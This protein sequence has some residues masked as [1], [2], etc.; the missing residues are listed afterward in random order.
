MKYCQNCQG[1]RE[2]LTN[3]KTCLECS[4]S[5][6]VS[7]SSQ[8]NK[9]EKSIA[10]LIEKVKKEK[11]EEQFIQELQG[12]H[13]VCQEFQAIQKTEEENNLAVQKFGQELIDKLL[14]ELNSR[15]IRI[16]NW[17]T[18]QAVVSS[19]RDNGELSRLIANE[20]E[21]KLQNLRGELGAKLENLP[22]ELRAKLNLEVEQMFSQEIQSLMG[23]LTGKLDLANLAS[24]SNSEVAAMYRQLIEDLK[25]GHEDYKTLKENLIEEIRT[26]K[27]QAQQA[28]VSEQ[29]EHVK[30]KQNKEDLIQQIKQVLGLDKKDELAENWITQIVKQEELVQE[31][32][33]HNLTKEKYQNLQTSYSSL[34]KELQT[35]KDNHAKTNSAL[36]TEQTEHKKTKE[37]L[38]A[39]KEV[40]QKL[41]TEFEKEKLAAEETIRLANEAKEAAI[42]EKNE[43]EV[44]REASQKSV[45]ELEKQLTEKENKNNELTTQ[46]AEKD[47]QIKELQNNNNSLTENVKELKECLENYQKYLHS[48][49]Q[50]AEEALTAPFFTEVQQQEIGQEKQE[51][52]AKILQIEQFIRKVKLAVEVNE[53]VK[54]YEEDLK[55]SHEAIRLAEETKTEIESKYVQERLIKE[56]ILQEKEELETK[57]KLV[58]KTGKKAETT[59]DIAEELSESV[60]SEKEE[61]QPT[62]P[63]ITVDDYESEKE[64]SENLLGKQKKLTELEGEKKQLEQAVKDLQKKGVDENELATSQANLQAKKKELEELRNQ[65]EQ[66][67]TAWEKLMLKKEV[68][69]QQQIQQLQDERNRLAGEKRILEELLAERKAECQEISNQLTEKEKEL[70]KT[71]LGQ[72]ELET[73]RA[74]KARLEGELRGA[75]KDQTRLENKLGETEQ[76]L[77]TNQKA[78]DLLLQEQ[79]QESDL[80][81]TVSSTEV[82]EKTLKEKYPAQE[83]LIGLENRVN[84]RPKTKEISEAKELIEKQVKS[85]PTSSSMK[86]SG[87]ASPMRRQLS[88]PQQARIQQSELPPFFKKD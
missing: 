60:G 29:I 51:Y 68:E 66:E 72:E 25:A 34:T 70:L 80:L 65:F 44:A 74:E 32:A 6:L 37:Q 23:S 55:A 13:Q 14:Q 82:K 45:T 46:F 20:L 7:L 88:N 49:I 18:R 28:L 1:F 8:I 27:N 10:Q 4:Q 31:Q 85:Q 63:E 69:A 53:L 38:A 62:L 35:E 19:F 48:Q 9:L 21:A 67:K 26:A 40:L 42:Q 11:I 5:S 73:L 81:L 56:Q 36:I 16:V 58:N 87:S 86:R 61:V 41:Q 59:L 77:Q 71:K 15:Q 3:N 54:K 64:E 83:E 17:E 22:Q 84:P 24:G 50:E 52:E 33:A 39:E 30:T 43:A 76:E 12:I 79:L 2:S 57:L 78:E 75:E 47:Q